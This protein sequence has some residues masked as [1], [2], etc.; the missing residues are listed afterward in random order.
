MEHREAGEK[1]N[2]VIVEATQEFSVGDVLFSGGHM[3]IGP[4]PTRPASQKTNYYRELGA[5]LLQPIRG[6]QGFMEK[7][8]KLFERG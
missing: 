6:A 1:I 5:F 7:G 3:K 4:C 8:S 2:S